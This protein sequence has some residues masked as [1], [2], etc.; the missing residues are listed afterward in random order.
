MGRKL[1]EGAHNASIYLRIRDEMKWAMI[2]RLMKY[3]KYTNNR[4]L[5]FNNALDYG[6]PKL[7][8]VE[9]GESIAL[10]EEKEIPTN[11][12]IVEQLRSIIDERFNL[13]I[14]ILKELVHIARI[15]K[16][17]VCSLYHAKCLEL[18]GFP[19]IVNHFERGVY[20]STPSFQIR[21][22]ELGENE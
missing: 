10:E 12:K 9:S 14:P 20:R 16:A 7:L 18:K 21:I 4:A 11:D 15:N 3:P 13:M 5:L 8:E 17:V 1:K 6:L 22:E 19:V 2:D